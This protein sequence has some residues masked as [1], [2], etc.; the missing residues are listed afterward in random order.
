[1]YSSSATRGVW[2][3]TY[4]SCGHSLSSSDT[5]NNSI[6][7]FSPKFDL[8]FLSQLPKIS[9]SRSYFE[10]SHHRTSKEFMFVL[11][12]RVSLRW[13]WPRSG[14]LWFLHCNTVA[15]GLYCL[16][17]TGKMLHL[18][19]HL[20]ARLPRNYID[21]KISQ[22]NSPTEWKR[23][24]GSLIIRSFTIILYKLSGKQVINW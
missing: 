3:I 7:V 4:P 8:C 24:E 16:L 5:Y 23:M 22:I 17:T 21:L 11:F 12:R 15:Q 19:S 9:T 1:M 18:I 6:C 2:I 10:V 13:I 20:S 14:S